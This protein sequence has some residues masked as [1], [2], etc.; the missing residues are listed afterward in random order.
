M[1]QTAVLNRAPLMSAAPFNVQIIKTT[2]LKYRKD[3][4]RDLTQLKT[5]G[6]LA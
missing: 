4:P 1:L 3:E 5:F 2:L 6:C